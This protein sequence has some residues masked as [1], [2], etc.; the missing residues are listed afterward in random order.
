MQ[1]NTYLKKIS[2][3]SV[4]FIANII[5]LF[6]ISLS[7]IYS[8]TITKTEPFFIKEIIWFVLG[9]MVFVVV[10]LIKKG[11]DFVIVALYIVDKLITKS[12]IIFAIKNTL[13]FDS[14]FK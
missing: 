2:K 7:T 12:S 14:F 10:S 5:L 6:V 3:F 9:L 1:N 8:A 4:F 11:S 13:N